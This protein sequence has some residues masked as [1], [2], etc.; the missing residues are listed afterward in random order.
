MGIAVVLACVG[1][2]FGFAQDTEPFIIVF[3]QEGCNSCVQLD[4]FLDA[5]LFDAPASTLVRYEIGEPESQRKL[6]AFSKAYDIEVPV[7]F[8]V[9]F[10]AD[11]VILGIDRQQELVMS[12]TIADC[13]RLGCESPIARLPIS[14]LRAD[15]PRLALFLTMFLALAW[16][17]LH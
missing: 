8:P 1:F 13:L 12:D 2:L 16:F 15:L 11:Q 17:Q 4:Q 5:M 9:V 6:T 7:S 3:Y 14:Q 10:V